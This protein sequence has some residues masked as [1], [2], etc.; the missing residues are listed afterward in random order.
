MAKKKDIPFHIIHSYKSYE[1]SDG[2]KF[3]AR[4]NSSSKLYKN[5]LKTL[6]TK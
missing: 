2:T 5:K 3:W 6:K 1:L 4:D